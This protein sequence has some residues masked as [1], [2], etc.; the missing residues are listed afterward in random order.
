MES[1][2]LEHYAKLAKTG[3]GAARR[4]SDRALEWAKSKHRRGKAV[5][6]GS[7]TLAAITTGLA[8]FDVDHLVTAAVAGLSALVSGMGLLRF[9]KE[10]AAEYTVAG[11]YKQLGA[12]YDNLRPLLRHLTPE[13]ATAKLDALAGEARRIQA[14][15]AEN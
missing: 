12:N 15:H 11:D 14:Y 8:G 4:D 9:D 1:S 5:V 2:D 3:A 6:W 13:E 10:S 7:I